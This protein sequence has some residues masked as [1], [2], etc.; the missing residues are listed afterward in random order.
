GPGL[1]L[2]LES[3][4]ARIEKPPGAAAPQCGAEPA[5]ARPAARGRPAGL[6]EAA[7]VSPE[8]ASSRDA[9]AVEERRRMPPP[10]PLS[11][12]RTATRRSGIAPM[13]PAVVRAEEVAV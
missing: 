9:M 1:Q 8:P 7:A 5:E 13:A 6:E 4:Q 3:C 10:A 2:C 12:S 11:E